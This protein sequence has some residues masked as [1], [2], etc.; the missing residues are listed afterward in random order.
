MSRTL[1]GTQTASI[2]AETSTLARIMSIKL[3]DA[4]MTYLTDLDIDLVIAGNTYKSAV[5]FE[6][7]AIQTDIGTNLSNVTVKL[8][9]TSGGITRAQVEAGLLDNAVISVS[10]VD[11]A[12]L[13]TPILLFT[14]QA[15]LITYDDDL[16]VSVE[17]EPL[18]AVERLISVDV[19]SKNCRYDFGDAN[20]TVN[21]DALKH[22]F[23]VT[24][25][26][27]AQQFEIAETLGAGSWGNGVLQFTS[28]ANAGLAMEVQNFDVPTKAVTMQL[29]LPSLIN[30]GDVGVIYPGCDKTVSGGCTLYANAIN[31]GGEPY[32]PD[33]AV[34]TTNSAAVT[35]GPTATNAVFVTPTPVPGPLPLAFTT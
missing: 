26:D 6:A 19:Y 9:L 31:F 34:T 24:N 14:G 2:S 29:L 21:I 28:G 32:V 10:V 20:C 12:I 33:I 23:T 35:T 30:I 7:S 11:W 8:F 13:G 16:T 5:G 22:T 3:R 17:V 1:D 25:V 18:L 15:K 4:S 27:N